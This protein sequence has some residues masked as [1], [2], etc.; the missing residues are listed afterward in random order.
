MCHLLLLL[1]L[2]VLPVFW[3]SPASIAVPVYTAAAL[4]SGIVY[5][6]ALKSAR[7]PK[8]NGAEAMLGAR[9]RVVHCRERRVTLFF[10]G[11]LWSADVDGEPLAV[12]DE[13]AVVGIEGLQLRVRK[14]AP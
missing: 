9:G 13:A 11:E 6:Y 2:L 7:M 14:A 4:V 10:H 8:L 1:P 3:L 12:G 5:W